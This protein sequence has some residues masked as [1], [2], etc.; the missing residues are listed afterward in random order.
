MQTARFK[1]G[2]FTTKLQIT[3]RSAGVPS[4]MIHRTQH[5]PLPIRLSQLSIVQNVQLARVMTRRLDSLDSPSGSSQAR[6]ELGNRITFRKQLKVLFR[7]FSGFYLTSTVFIL[8]SILKRTKISPR[9]P[10]EANECIN[11]ANTGNPS[12]DNASMCSNMYVGE[13]WCPWFG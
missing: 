7:D 11:R 6:R 5:L 2:E 1:N 10:I 3:V 4:T 12:R 13:G 9:Q 8:L